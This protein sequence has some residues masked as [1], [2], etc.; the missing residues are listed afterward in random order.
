MDLTLVVLAAGLSTRYG[1]LK[2]LEP[3]G[4]AGEAL[5][6]YGIYDAVRFGF[7]KVILVAR[8][9][10]EDA[11]REHMERLFGTSVAFAFAYQELGALPPGFSLPAERVK[12][13]GT[14]HAVLSAEAEVNGPF[15]AINADDFYGAS[16]YAALAGHLRVQRD[17]EIPEF[18]AAGYTLRDT[19]S[20]HGGVSRGV[21]EVDA[22]GYLTR[23]T[24]V[25]KIEDVNGTLAGLTVAGQRYV[26]DGSETI[27][28]NIWAATRAA[29]PLLREKFSRFLEDHIS[30]PDSEF[31]LSTA[32]NDLISAGR[33]RVKVMPASGPW[34]GVTF[35]DDRPYVTEKL[36]ELVEA[37]DYPADISAAMHRAG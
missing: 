13:W 7:T 6:D 24:E 12:P 34:L 3:V 29:F 28:M 10:L 35:Q 1:R 2:Q 5:M 16:A 23:V 20:V 37:R 9:E 21:C 18:A 17:A 4:P 25:Q 15:V 31:L 11:L 33:A 32:V 26:L 36:R 19:L 27:S 14:G 22:D 8:R 30:D